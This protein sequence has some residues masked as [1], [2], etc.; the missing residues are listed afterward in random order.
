[1][2]SNFGSIGEHAPHRLANRTNRHV[3][4][5]PRHRSTGA[6]LQQ[7]AIAQDH[8]LDFVAVDEYR[9]ILGAQMEL[10]LRLGPFDLGVVIA[11]D[12]R[13]HARFVVSAT[14]DSHPRLGICDRPATQRSGKV[15]QLSAHV[16]TILPVPEPAN[17]PVLVEV[18]VE[19]V[20]GAYAAIVGGA[21]RIELCSSLAEGGLTP[22][23]GLCA[24][25]CAAV[26][27]PV[28]AMVRPR[29]GDFLYDT[30]EIDVM[31]RDIE[32]LRDAGAA[33]IVTGT[34]TSDGRIDHRRMAEF[35][36]L[37]DGL[38]VTCHRAFDM[39]RDAAEGLEVM[40]DLG[41]HR[42]LTSGQKA[43]AYDGRALIRELVQQADGRIVVMAGCGVRPDNAER[44]VEVTGVREVHLSASGSRD[45]RMAFRR[46]EV[47]MGSASGTAEY[48]LRTTEETLI[49]RVVAALRDC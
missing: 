9:A 15:Q 33:G 2:S 16:P 7:I 43:T 25:V 42:V 28:F 31:A 22:S 38:P 1:V 11:D 5:K 19:S 46:D 40:C 27:V 18:C 26:K 23:V 49:A 45:S 48:S 41:V 17:A 39:C 12:L 36:D 32:A 24:A 13:N 34:L 21:Q 6:K 8:F 37:A 47:T 29:A 3:G 30:T 44:L 35:V 10:A 14:A 20:A 4:A